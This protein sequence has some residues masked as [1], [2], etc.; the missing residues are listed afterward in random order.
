LLYSAKNADY[1]VKHDDWIASEIFSAPLIPEWSMQPKKNVANPPM[2]A[3]D[4]Q[5]TLQKYS[6]SSHA[7]WI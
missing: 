5:E 4:L 7:L 3:V 1:E 6:G 2:K